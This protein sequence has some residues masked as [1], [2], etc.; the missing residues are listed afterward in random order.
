MVTL[1]ETQQMYRCI[2]G[3]EMNE[4]EFKRNTPEVLAQLERKSSDEVRS[5]MLVSDEFMIRHKFLLLS[6]LVPRKAVVAVTQADG[7]EIYVDLRQKFIGWGVLQ[8]SYEPDETSLIRRVV[9]PGMHVIDIGANI[10]YYTIMTAAIVG[11]TGRVDS[12]EPV[13]Q[14][15]QLLKRSVDRNEF[16][17]FVHLHHIALSSTERQVRMRYDENSTNMGGAY[18]EYGEAI[19]PSFPECPV[20]EEI[21]QASTLDR[22]IDGRNIDFIKIDVEGAEPIVLEGANKVLERSRPTILMEVNTAAL[23]AVSGRSPDW[24]FDRFGSLDYRISNV[25]AAGLGEHLDRSEGLSL[26][27]RTDLCSLLLVHQSHNHIAE[28]ML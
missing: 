7:T 21:V 8:G 27:E 20:A 12:F 10:G 3:R 16:N 24:V 4:L 14:S 5:D 19:L 11:P 13:D 26:F 28:L 1:N 9:R 6:K 18:M 25:T 15:F 23:R 2:L 17:Q 22:I